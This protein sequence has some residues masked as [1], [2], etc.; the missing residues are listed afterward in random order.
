MGVETGKAMAE[1]AKG[2]GTGQEQKKILDAARDAARKGKEGFSAWW[3][4]NK[5]HRP[6]ANTIID[7]L[8]SLAAEADANRERQDEDDPFANEQEDTPTPEQLAE[9]ERQA[10]EWA[11]EQAKR[12]R[13]AGQ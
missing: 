1:W 12:D 10:R 8:K 6:L 4:E 11:E 7:Q 3:A 5:E 9:A 2:D 13:E